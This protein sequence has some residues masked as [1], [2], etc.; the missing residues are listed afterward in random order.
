VG[1]V[2]PEP[3]KSEVIAAIREELDDLPTLHTFDI[4]DFAATPEAF[5]KSALRGARPIVPAAALEEY[6]EEMTMTA[7]DEVDLTAFASALLR[8]KGALAEPKSDL[9]RDAAIQRFE[10]SFELAW[11]TA[12]RVMRNAG[13][14]SGAS[15]KQVV[16]AAFKL[17]WIGDDRLWLDMLEDRNRTTHIYDEEM[18]DEIYA[19]LPGY[20]TAL[21]NLLERLKLELQS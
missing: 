18:A 16:R 13:V 15:P 6:A 5:R 20:H 7:S 11:K 2:G 17:G 9:V 12:A 10:F 3:L 19:H 4:V 14:D 8:L 1:V 21:A